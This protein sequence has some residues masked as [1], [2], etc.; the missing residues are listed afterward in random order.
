MHDAALEAGSLFRALAAR[1]GVVLPEPVRGV[2]AGAPRPVAA[3]ESRRLVDLVTATLRYSN[4]QMA[5]LI[6]L[7]TS[8]ELAGHSLGLGESASAV[9][10]HLQGEIPALRSPPPVLPNHSGL[11]ASAR[12]TPR[13]LVALLVH[14]FA[15]R[16]SVPGLP[17]LLP[18]GG[19]EGTLE[20][21]FDGPAQVLDVWAKTGTLDGA[22]TLAGYLLEPE[23]PPRAFAIMAAAPTRSTSGETATPWVL[24]ARALEDDIVAG[25]LDAAPDVP[26]R[27]SR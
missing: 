7:A 8:K 16:A 9:L 22:S 19:F 5:E 24:R 23:R 26:T 17:A 18:T 4:N 2:P 12:L 20:R 3:H 1:L 14:G 27:G 25:W 11:A 15:D 13:Q 6:G 10:R 21:R